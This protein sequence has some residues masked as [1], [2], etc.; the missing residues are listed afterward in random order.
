MAEMAWMPHQHS[1]GNK[2]VSLLSNSPSRQSGLG[3]SELAWLLNMRQI[4]C[5]PSARSSR[6]VMCCSQP[7]AVMES[8][9]S[10]EAMDSLGCLEQPA[11]TLLGTTKRLSVLSL[12]PN[13]RDV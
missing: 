10:K 2:A 12:S 4:T 11:Q 3:A 7:K 6:E 8:L 5:Q 1:P 13:S 9:V